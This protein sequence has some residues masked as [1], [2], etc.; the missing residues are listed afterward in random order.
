MTMTQSVTH[1]KRVLLFGMLALQLVSGRQASVA[2]SAHSDGKL[3]MRK[4]MPVGVKVDLDAQQAYVFMDKLVHVVLPKL[5]DFA[6]F[7]R[8]SSVNP[9]RPGTVELQFDAEAWQSFPE[10]EASYLKFP[11]NGAVGCLQ[12]FSVA[13]HTTAKNP[14]EARL[15]MSGFRIPLSIIEPVPEEEFDP[16]RSVDDDI[17]DV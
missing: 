3:K 15:L 2:M 13:F 7:Q 17:Q 9:A 1:S 11:Q 12:P 6:G 16:R 5:R 4:G 10:I 14:E 8:F